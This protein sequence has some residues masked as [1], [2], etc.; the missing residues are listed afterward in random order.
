MI[1]DLDS[2]PLSP[3]Q[4]RTLKNAGFTQN[5][6]VIELSPS[7]LS[8]ELCIPLKEA[9]D[10][11]RIVKEQNQNVPL[12]RSAFDLLQEEEQE[13]HIV[14]FCAAFDEM[15]GGGIPLGKITEFCG[16]PG[17][18]KTQ[19]GIQ[20]A[21]DSIIPEL[22]GGVGGEAIYIDCEGSFI[23]ERVVEIA[24]AASHH[25]KSVAENNS[26]EPGLQEALDAFSLQNILKKIHVFR[27]HDYVQ[28]IALSHTLPGFIKENSGK[29]KI[30]IL[31]SIAFHFRHDFEDMALRT[32][33]LHGLVQSFMKMACEHC[34]AV[35]IMN[36]MTT[37]IS[38]DEQH[39]KLIPALGT[40]W[41]HACTIRIVLQTVDGKRYGHLLKSPMMQ[42]STAPFDIT[43]DGIRDVSE[44]NSP[45][46]KGEIMSD[47]SKRN[48]IGQYNDEFGEQPNKRLRP[49]L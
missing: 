16:G 29:V 37:K 25:I 18:G 48:L 43:I 23:C 2:Y 15:V 24:Q 28:L 35:V 32:R 31:D 11:L 9:L 1:R 34:L 13:T 36:Q 46:E 3:K 39:S 45:P 21:V 17:M 4:L 20:L 19:F 6:D 22:F 38:D 49:E 44:D 42:E 5:I 10:I 33:L 47:Y 8:E 41:G 26:E 30:I 12:E 7:Q 27:C 40:S 14:T